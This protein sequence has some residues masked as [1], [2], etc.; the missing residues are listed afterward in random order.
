[1]TPPTWPCSVRMH[2]ITGLS[3]LTAHNITYVHD[4]EALKLCNKRVMLDI[5][6]LQMV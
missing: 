1:M 5:A 2:A 3:M 4:N 6:A